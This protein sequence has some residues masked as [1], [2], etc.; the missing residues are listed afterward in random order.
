MITIS[1]YHPP[2]IN[3]LDSMA[4]AKDT[5]I[6][7]VLRNSKVIA[8]VGASA[9]PERPSYGVMQY[10]LANGFEVVPVNPG[11]AGTKLMGQTV[12]A[13]LADIPFPVDLVD[14]FRESSA[15]PGVVDEAIAIKAKA[16][17]LQLG[18]SNKDAEDKA[19]QAGLHY[20]E[21]A[22][23]KIDHARLKGSI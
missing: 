17:W 16:V 6:I 1:G 18:I 11:Q 7:D 19:R 13:T 9:K 5:E 4:D 22:C 10:L 12:Y 8:M 15:T 21:N 14:V 3:R 23:I 20:V 2:N